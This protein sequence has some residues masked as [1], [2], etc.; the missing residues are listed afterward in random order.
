MLQ[1]NDIRSRDK[2][3]T[4]LQYLEEFIAGKYPELHDFYESLHLNMD[5]GGS[6]DYPY[7]VTS[8]IY[9][10]N[11]FL[12]TVSYEAISSDVIGLRKGLDVV[13]FEV[14]RQPTNTT[15]ADF[16]DS[17]APVVARIAE[18]FHKMQSD[19]K[20]LCARFAEDFKTVNSEEIFKPLAD[21]CKAFEVNV[22]Q[23]NFV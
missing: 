12:S 10:T 4:L 11:V 6:L 17:A 2:S 13:K 7:P 9:K 18:A 8:K 3:K 1:L 5:R 21:F 19:Y 20:V 16:H 14:G 15:I 23:Q 22:F